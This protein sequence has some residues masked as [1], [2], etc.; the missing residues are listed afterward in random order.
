MIDLSSYVVATDGDG[1]S[2]P[3]GAGT[4]TVTVLDDI[5]VVTARP[6]TETTVTT[7]ETITYT[8]QAGNTDVRGMDGQ[9]NHDIKLT[10]VDINR[11]TTTAST[12]P[13]SRSA[14][15]TGRALMALETHPG[16][17]GPE[18]LT[19]EFLSNFVVGVPNIIAYDVIFDD[20]QD[21][22]R[23]SPQHR[24]RRRLRVGNQQRCFRSR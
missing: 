22:C 3:L 9:N 20:L 13:A 19:M 6:P 5:P 1:D 8:L 15:A 23:G 24:E 10:G 16:I 12:R 11:Q 2:I 18:I 14:S 17:S 4:F 21:R 7:T